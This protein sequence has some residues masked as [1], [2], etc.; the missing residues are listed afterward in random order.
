MHG[1][2][3]ARTGGDRGGHPVDND[4]D[5]CA[6]LSD[7]LGHRSRRAMVVECP[8]C[9]VRPGVIQATQAESPGRPIGDSAEMLNPTARNVSLMTLGGCSPLLGRAETIRWDLVVKMARVN[10]GEFSVVLPF[11]IRPP[12]VVD[13]I[14]GGSEPSRSRRPEL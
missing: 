2:R 9:A 13:L 12:A 8:P 1:Q 11:D 3:E 5:R 7:G 10:T 4:D 14:G 6:R